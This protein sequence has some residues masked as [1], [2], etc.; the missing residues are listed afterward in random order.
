MT[1]SLA[2]ILQRLL[3][4]KSSS[5]I[6]QSG[7][8]RAELNDLTNNQAKR[9]VALLVSAAELGIPQKFA[10]RGA[11]N[12]E[13]IDVALRLAAESL[14]DERGVDAESAE[15]TVG[16][17]AVALGLI[18][19]S[20]AAKIDSKPFSTTDVLAA[21]PTPQAPPPLPNVTASPVSMPP[22]IPTTKTQAS[23]NL[24]SMPPPIPTTKTQV[25]GN[26]PSTPPPIPTAKSQET[27]TPVPVIQPPIPSTKRFSLAHGVGITAVLLCIIGFVWWANRNSGNQEA[28]ANS[29]KQLQPSARNEGEKEAVVNSEKQNERI[30]R[31]KAL[32]GDLSISTN[33]NS[34]I[35]IADE[36]KNK[37]SAIQKEQQDKYDAASKQGYEMDNT[38]YFP[39]LREAAIYYE[40]AIQIDT[41]VEISTLT[42]L[43]N[44]YDV[45]DDKTNYNRT[46]EYVI[47]LE[48]NALN[49]A[50]YYDM[51]GSIYVKR[52]NSSKAE[53]YF[54]KAKKLR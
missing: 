40:R 1:K 6:E 54:Q 22:P 32:I 35:E 3:I 13:P 5:I 33:K 27:R 2:L 19:E 34:I 48:P 20:D 18:T 15:W 29:E 53:E 45:L 11:T 37:A 42:Q 47:S 50:N 23:R 44:I 16:T 51:L 43:L 30:N 46:A 41:V 7:N 28:V 21:N 17:W 52:R 14:H 10:Q 8:L 24:P 26:L 25:S 39:Y 4:E 36:L 31:L 38:R 9:E 49:N 12:A